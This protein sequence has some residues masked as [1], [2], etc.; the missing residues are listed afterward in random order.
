[1]S[2]LPIPHRSALGGIT[3]ALVCLV[4]PAPLF[5][6]TL[7]ERQSKVLEVVARARP[8]VV[9]IQSRSGAAMG[10]GSGVATAR[11][12]EKLS[13]SSMTGVR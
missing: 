7:K 11:P 4:A 6:E 10:S 12:R 3:S 1:M 8:A 9:C 5:A 2:S 13:S